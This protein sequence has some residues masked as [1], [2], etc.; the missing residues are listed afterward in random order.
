MLQSTRPHTVIKSSV[1]PPQAKLLLAPHICSPSCT[2]VAYCSASA[3]S[4]ACRQSVA[5]YRLITQYCAPRI[6]ALVQRDRAQSR[7]S[8]Q[9][10][11][12]STADEDRRSCRSRRSYS[13]GYTHVLA[14]RHKKLAAWEEVG[15]SLDSGTHARCFTM[16]HCF[17][18]V[19]H[20][21]S[22]S[23]ADVLAHRHKKLASWV[24]VLASQVWASS[25]RKHGELVHT[26]AVMQPDNCVA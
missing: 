22:Q 23:R 12:V 14:H 7:C 2:V 15:A 1:V 10:A 13:G 17:T 6:L 8:G 20:R 9:R 16:L 11:R 19:A 24:W 18:V 4:K 26:W 25:T 21:T 3:F 5:L